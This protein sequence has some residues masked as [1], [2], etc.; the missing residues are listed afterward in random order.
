MTNYRWVALLLGCLTWGGPA[1]ATPLE[2]TQS[3]SC[4]QIND[5]REAVVYASI[6]GPSTRASLQHVRASIA[7]EILAGS[8]PDPRV[9]F[10]VAPLSIS[11][12]DISFGVTAQAS[13]ELPWPRVL[14]L[15]RRAA[16]ADTGVIRASAAEVNASAALEAATQ[17]DALYLAEQGLVS[18]EEE[19]QHLTQLHETALAMVAG[20][21]TSTS[22]LL[23]VEGAIA[24]IALRELYWQTHKERAHL[25][26]VALIGE[27]IDLTIRSHEPCLPGLEMT[28]QQVQH[29]S[30]IGAI[31][32]VEATSNRVKLANMSAIPTPILTGGLTSMKMDWEHAVTIGIGMN[33]PLP[34]SVT[35]RR[36]GAESNHLA[37]T[38]DLQWQTERLAA[39]LEAARLETERT[40]AEAH[41]I[42][43]SIIPLARQFTELIRHR[44]ATGEALMWEAIQAEQS[45]TT[46]RM[47]LN[48][49]ASRAW[50]AHSQFQWAS[51]H[52]AYPVSE[53]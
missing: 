45:L 11:A 24:A 14:T 49:S 22:D 36:E 32:L 3:D 15:Q 51:G 44:V 46:A 47:Q 21:S 29:P 18:L 6:Y 28:G 5:L 39:E 48:E 26:L 38:L 16:E 42:E 17:F 8:L 12:D 52:Y 41:V 31:A 37:A 27:D 30:I 50:S 9:S 20:G 53:R 1:V 19:R 35:T 34:S 7:G 23:Q 33:I 25:R 4:L 2:T 10:G 13:Q 40:L 43:S